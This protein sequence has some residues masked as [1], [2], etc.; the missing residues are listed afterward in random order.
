MCHLPLWDASFYALVWR[1]DRDLAAL[2]RKRGCRHCGG[3]LHVA[4]YGRKPRCGPWVP[5]GGFEVR[6]SFCCGREGCR[7]RRTPPSVR[8]LGR[9]VFLGAV[10]V[11]VSALRHGATPKR[12]AELQRLFGVSPRT[13]E[14]WRRWW[15]ETFGSSPFWWSLR[16]RLCEPPEPATL[17]ASLLERLGGPVASGLVALLTLLGPISTVPGLEAVAD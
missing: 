17:P 10:V 5:P 16:G 6:L 2:A 3:G 14:R 15:R 9:R 8:F 4:N 7:R 13:L 1:I 11:L 12:S